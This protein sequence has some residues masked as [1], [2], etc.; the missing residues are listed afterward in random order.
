MLSFTHRTKLSST[1]LQICSVL[2]LL[3]FISITRAASLQTAP[4]LAHILHNT[5]VGP[6]SQS[7]APAPAHG[8]PTPPTEALMN[9][10]LMN[11]A[12]TDMTYTTL[13]II[14][15]N[16]VYKRL[17]PSPHIEL[18]IGPTYTISL[19]TISAQLKPS[20]GTDDWNVIHPFDKDVPYGR[21]RIGYVS[22]RN[23]IVKDPVAFMTE[24]EDAVYQDQPSI[25]WRDE[26]YRRVDFLDSF[27]RRLKTEHGVQMEEEVIDH[28]KV[29]MHQYEVRWDKQSELKRKTDLKHDSR[30][31]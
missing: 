6:S 24:V 2:L 28:W 29:A 31:R 22:F 12:P 14:F 20:K 8:A 23:D 15:T 5:D 17:N 9:G 4:W 19:H 1:F 21:K 18:A 30:R 25:H 13:E 3:C 10:A 16:F 27:L 7:E 26:R 11:E